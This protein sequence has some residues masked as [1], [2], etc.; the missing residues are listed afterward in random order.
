[1]SQQQPPIFT[2]E[3]KPPNWVEIAKQETAGKKSAGYFRHIWEGLKEALPEIITIVV[4]MILNLAARII[5]PV[6]RVIIAAENRSESALA[7]LA[8]VAT[9]DL[10]GVKAPRGR[11]RDRG[12]SLNASA[13]GDAV[14]DQVLRAIIGE[15]GSAGAGGIQPSMIP[16]RRY[17]STMV[18]FSIEG[19]LEGWIA[20]LASIGQLEKFADLDDML[21]QTLG[22][23]RLSRRVLGPA[24]DILLVTPT[25]W[26]LNKTYRP[27]LL[28]AGEAVRQFVR[29]RMTRAQLSEELARQGYDESRIE[30]LIN[31]ATR[32][33]PD[34][35]VALLVRNGIWTREQAVTELVDQGWTRARAETLLTVEETRRIDTWRNQAVAGAVNAF[36]DGGI[37]KDVLRETV[38]SLGVQSPELDWIVTSAGLRREINTKSISLG[39]AQEAFERGIFTLSQFRAYLRG[40]NYAPGDRLTI[41]LLALADIQDQAAADAKRKQLDDERKAEAARRRAEAEARRQERAAELAVREV[42]MGDYEALV[43]RGI[44][45]IAQYR[46]FLRQQKLTEGD[47]FALADLLEAEIGEAKAER[48]RRAAIAAEPKAREIGL[49]DVESAVKRGILTIADYGRIVSDAGYNDSDRAILV[50]L[51]QAE[52][53]QATA[54]AAA[55]A[56]AKTRLARQEISLS[57]QERLVRLGLVGLDRYEQFL[58]GEGFAESDAALLRA[59]LAQEIAADQAARDKRAEAEARARAKDISLVDLERAVRAGLR[60]VNDYRLTLTRAGFGPVDVDALVRLL[61]LAIEVDQAAADKRAEAASRAAAKQISLPDLERAVRLG[62]V[63]IV[64]YTAALQR[65]GFPSTDVDILRLSLLAELGEVQRTRERRAAEEARRGSRPVTIGQFE[66][67]VRAGRRSLIEYQQFLDQE[68]VPANFSADFAALL[69]QDIAAR[70]AAEGR[71][72]EAERRAGDKQLSLAQ[73]ESGVLAGVRT[74]ADYDQFLNQIGFT[75]VDRPILVGVLRAR[76]A[77]EEAA[78]ERRRQ[79]EARS[80]RRGVALGQF[81]AAVRAGIRATGDYDQFLNQQG[82]DQADRAM[83]VGLVEAQIAEDRAARDRRAQLEAEGTARALTLGQFGRAVKEGV[84]SIAEYEAFLVDQNYDPL[85]Q[86]TLVEL[87]QIELAAA[88]AKQ[89]Q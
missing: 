12:G 47:V 3:S 6:A 13:T 85:D 34:S 54:A 57:E 44:R 83:L 87:L 60:S 45:T 71:R 88:A 14:G 76:K 77:E 40:E 89:A 17:L 64:E 72:R 86:S 74:L 2:T 37:D 24:L 8:D 33:L 62:V 79:L 1:M 73:F 78:R 20:E 61:E 15:Y 66:D 26:M 21:A 43:R 10:L 58:R 16:A 5:V 65:E 69:A 11:G 22:F 51:L 27:R 67:L 35:D 56:E 29:G 80:A 31:A 70:R 4:A 81:E 63:P 36:L 7:D 82:F 41:E 30:A 28:A 18:N 53:D 55:R 9:E 52:L 38:R 23:G 59:A 42:S 25:E 50:G 84:R 48:D 39:Q 49:A 32:F 46:D 68:G 19:W 75:Y